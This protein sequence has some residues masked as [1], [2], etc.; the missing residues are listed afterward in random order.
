M[1]ELVETVGTGS[2]ENG[3]RKLRINERKYENIN[4]GNYEL[5]KIHN[6]KNKNCA[7][8]IR[9]VKVPQLALPPTDISPKWHLPQLPVHRDAL[10]FVVKPALRIFCM[11]ITSAVYYKFNHIFFKLH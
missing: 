4:K 3:F 10:R 6:N 9:Q 2:P 5:C 8:E 11:K 7:Q 1:I